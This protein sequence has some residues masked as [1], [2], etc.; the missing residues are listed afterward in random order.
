M[1]K[2][3][4]SVLRS[5]E[6][7]GKLA[8]ALAYAHDNDVVH[9]DVKPHNV[10]LDQHDEPHLM[11]FGLAKRVD[12]DAKVTTDGSVLG[13]PAYMSPEQ[14][15]GEVSAVGP[16]SDQ[17][18]LAVMLFQFLTGSTPFHGPPHLVIAEVAK[19]EVPP[20]RSVRKDIPADLAAVC[21]RA[22]QK[23]PSQRYLTCREFAADL[24][25]W[26][27]RRPVQTRRQGVLQRTIRFA[28]ANKAMIGFWGVI[29][30]LLTSIAFAI[31]LT[32][33]GNKSRESASLPDQRV[34][35][36]LNSKAN[37]LT[38]SPDTLGSKDQ[39]TELTKIDKA[40]ATDNTSGTPES[41]S[42]LDNAFAERP[43]AIAEPESDKLSESSVAEL[44]REQHIL[45]RADIINGV[46]EALRMVGKTGYGHV[47][48]GQIKMEGNASTSDV[49]AQMEILDDGYFVDAVAMAGA[50]VYFWHP[51]YSRLDVVPH[52]KKG[53]VENLG[54]VIMSVATKPAGVVKGIMVANGANVPKDLKVTLTYSLPPLNKCIKSENAQSNLPGLSVQQELLSR[55]AATS[56][57]TVEVVPETGEFKFAN[58]S[59]L[60]FH[61]RFES[62]EKDHWDL[63]LEVSPGEEF[64]VGQCEMYRSDD[65]EQTKSV[66]VNLEW[67]PD[68]MPEYQK[69]LSNLHPDQDAFKYF[70]K[71]FDKDLKSAERVR[72]NGDERAAV[73]LVGQIDVPDNHRYEQD[74]RAQMQIA[75]GGYFVPQSN[76]VVRLDVD[77]MDTMP[78]HYIPKGSHDGVEYCGTFQYR[79]IPFQPGQNRTMLPFILFRTRVVYIS[80]IASKTG[81]FTDESVRTSV[82]DTKNG[83]WRSFEEA[84]VYGTYGSDLGLEQYGNAVVAQVSCGPCYIAD[85]GARDLEECR[86][87]DV[88]AT[89][90]RKDGG[91]NKYL[92]K[93]G[94]VYLLKQWH[95]KHW[96]L[97][98]VDGITLAPLNEK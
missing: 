7:I 53:T 65:A 90:T 18:S 39:G 38:L 81:Q 42:D 56:T 45:Q 92:L 63:E 80:H 88:D 15:R 32:L 98:K 93:E 77:C 66:L 82:M 21:D 28:S 36:D 10:M 34:A 85:L 84:A 40:T 30:L 78:W 67:A 29:S 52:G 89:F 22:L 23:E 12:D 44:L 17:Y 37:G 11:D 50:P 1:K 61:A 70:E 79:D 76:P 62:T 69:I 19:G 54:E 60:R 13:T 20:I 59:G 58:L 94:H 5:V 49:I 8:D 83:K 6:I 96:V 16:A 71:R 47:V 73:V 26:A 14:A 2:Q 25:N 24:D 86:F 75:T 72:N 64:D 3:Q 4:L 55:I 27:H 31:G 48:V 91:F 97:F 41:I 68:G 35:I 95:W 46:Q 51:G 33:Y 9:R 74:V 43:S 57:E 87:I